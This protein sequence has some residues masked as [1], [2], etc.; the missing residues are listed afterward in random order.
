MICWTF[1]LPCFIDLMQT[2]SYN[3]DGF[4]KYCNDNI[5]YDYPS[6]SF[7]LFFSII[8]KHQPPWGS[9]FVT[10]LYVRC[11][12]KMQWKLIPQKYSNEKQG[13]TAWQQENYRLTQ[14]NVASKQFFAI[15]IFHTAKFKWQLWFSIHPSIIYSPYSQRIIWGLVPISSSHQVRA[16]VHS[17]QV[18]VHCR[19]FKFFVSIFK[20]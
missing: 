5:D 1:L 19:Q 8:T 14:H 2:K 16:G 3:C 4:G 20:C 13:F 11:R 7:S 18:A 9:I 12:H 10:K 6:F 15:A 17:G